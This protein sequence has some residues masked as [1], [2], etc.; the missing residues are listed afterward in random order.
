[1][2]K[3]SIPDTKKFLYENLNILKDSNIQLYLAVLKKLQKT[4]HKKYSGKKNINIYK[5]PPTCTLEMPPPVIFIGSGQIEK[6]N[7]LES[8]NF[9][10][11]WDKTMNQPDPGESK[12]V[13]ARG[14]KRGILIETSI[15]AFS[16]SLSFIKPDVLKL[17]YVMI[18]D[19]PV[20]IN[21]A[22]SQLRT[23]DFDFTRAIISVERG[24]RFR[25]V[26]FCVSVLEYI[27]N[28]IEI[29][30]ASAATEMVFKK[31][32]F[33]NIKK[34]IRFFHD[35]IYPTEK[36][37]ARFSGT[38]ILVASGPWL[39]DS[40]E[41]LKDLSKLYP[42]FS[43]LPSVDFLLSN[44]IT[45]ELVLTSDPG[46]GNRYRISKSANL[47]LFAALSTDPVLL[48]NWNGDVL[49]FSHSTEQ[50]KK[51]SIVHRSLLKLPMEGT[52]A[53]VLIRVAEKLGFGDLLL[54]GYDFCFKGMMD[55]HRGAGFENYFI[56]RSSRFSPLYSM[57][58]GY[59]SGDFLLKARLRN[60]KIVYTTK[61][62]LLYRSWLN[63]N[64]GKSRMVR[65]TQGL[66]IKGIPFI[67]REDSFS[68]D[69]ISHQSVLSSSGKN[70]TMYDFRKDMFEV[71]GS[72]LNRDVVKRDLKWIE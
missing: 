22:I 29:E 12:I 46:F 58:L 44:G 54:F 71:L 14:K 3:S 61:K 25:N 45:P 8:F 55:H 66:E 59:I 62:L 5:H 48:R 63:E 36:L 35:R 11:Q 38:A 40:I 43:L 50:D 51:L 68:R 23:E 41:L 28:R 39:E 7:C 13:D 69:D 34:N 4:L 65:F 32:W 57:K 64:S 10:P 42:V 72:P 6:I 30:T 33:R 60:N 27:R 49:F 47:V 17:L 19:D 21:R 53:I 56:T 15:D 52:S 26:R 70:I 2:I 16:S 67:C 31:L 18:S 9:H 37:T 1:M 24:F 20:Y